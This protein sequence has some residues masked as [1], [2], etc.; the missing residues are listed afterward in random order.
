VEYQKQG[1]LHR[2]K[3]FELQLTRTKRKRQTFTL[4]AISDTQPEITETYT[5]KAALWQRE[6]QIN[7]TGLYWDVYYTTG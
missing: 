6:D 2:V 7:A 4:H 1:T 5:D 3:P